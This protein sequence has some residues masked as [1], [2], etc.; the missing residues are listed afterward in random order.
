M[1]NFIFHNPTKLVFGKGQIAKLANLIPADKRIMIT[2]GGGSVRRNGVYDQVVK[3]LEGRDWV[4]FWGIEPNPSVETVREAIALGRENKSDFLLAVGGGSVIDGTK[5]IAAGLLYDGDPWEIVLEGKAGKTVPLGTV[6]TMSATGSE[7]NSGAV[8]SRQET[9]EKF[10]FYGDY[11]LFSI[12]DPETLFS[13]PQKQIAYGLADTYVHVLEQYMTTPAQSRLM[14]H[15]AEGIL[16]TV[17]EIVPKIRENQHDYAVMSEYMLAATLALNDMIR[18]GVTQDWATHMIGHEL[19]AL[20]GL[21]HGATLAIVIN[22]TLRVLREQKRGKLLQY[23]ERIWGI[24]GGSEEE[25]IDRTIAANEE[26]FRS[27]GLST[28]LAE[29]GIGEATIAEIERRFNA[30]G[31][32][33]GEAQN[34]DGA[35]ARRILEA[36]L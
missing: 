35:M 14:D 19:T 33:F 9:K 13:L 20:H 10:A 31:V 36:A 3:A 18:M 16:H 11:P 25:R 24:T 6:L 8:I 7:M 29:E 32:K 2:F 12:L 5:L 17:I 1:N 23:G 26:F 30:A 27:L 4:E 15:W 28:H 22:G 34:V 21:T